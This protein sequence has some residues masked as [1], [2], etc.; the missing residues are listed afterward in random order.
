VLV[1]APHYS[2]LKKLLDSD[3]YHLFKLMPKPTVHHT[4]LTACADK[5]FLLRMTEQDE[6]YYSEKEKKFYCNGTKPAPIGY[7]PVNLLRAYE[8]DTKKFDDRLM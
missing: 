4:H 5:E 3:L 2:R 8:K 7:I 6:V 1:T